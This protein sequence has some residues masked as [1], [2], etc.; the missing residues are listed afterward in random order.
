MSL[1]LSKLEKFEE[2]YYF[3]IYSSNWR[4][5]MTKEETKKLAYTL[6]D[7]VPK[8]RDKFFMPLTTAH[9]SEI[10]VRQS[11]VLL[12]LAHK[13]PLTMTELADVAGISN[14][15]LTSVVNSLE[16]QKYVIRTPLPNNKRTIKIDI[17]EAG[18]AILS[19]FRDETCVELC[20]LLKDV[21]ED[22][23]KEILSL[24]TRLFEVLDRYP[25]GRENSLKRFE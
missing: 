13:G 21:K 22:D 16:E 1:F 23:A 17:T 11:D 3:N 12:S 25:D 7:I 8:L 14:Q 18:V 20:K 5:Q 2:I 4:Q 6:F 9:I 24:V 19:D 15:L 10:T